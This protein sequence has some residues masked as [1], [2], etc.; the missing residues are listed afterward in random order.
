MSTPKWKIDNVDKMRSY[1]RKHYR[2][3]SE[4]YKLRAKV[5]RKEVKDWVREIKSQSGCSK[6]GETHPACIDFH[7]PGNKEVTGPNGDNVTTLVRRGFSRQRIL[8]EIEKCIP[9]C[10]NCH[11]KLHDTGA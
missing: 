1:R 2:E 6:C 4:P 9:L 7:H 11:R 3:N 5:V 8:K 10:S